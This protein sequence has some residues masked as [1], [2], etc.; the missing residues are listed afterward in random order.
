MENATKA[1]TMAASILMALVIIG[2][3]LLV[4]NNLSKYQDFND[5]LTKDKHVIEFNNRFETYNRTDVRGSDLLSLINKVVDYNERQSF[6]GKEGSD[7]GYQPIK[8]TIDLGKNKT[9]IEV[10][11]ECDSDERII[12]NNN[13]YVI[14]YK[15][16]DKYEKTNDMEEILE[17][18]NDI[19]NTY[20]QTEL[21]KLV[22]AI[23]SIFIEGDSNGPEQD[24]AI[25]TYENI[26]GNDVTW[27][28][29]G[30]GKNIRKDVYKYSE[31]IQFKRSHFNCS[32][33]S[34]GNTPG[35]VYDEN[36]GRIIEM[37][38]VGNGKIE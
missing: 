16:T 5:Q 26:T 4:F 20:G 23:N 37:Y 21:T 36:T 14:Y 12:T 13:E 3:V 29:I 32:K 34:E 6:V 1:L 18:I 7:L 2:S 10:N 31:Y 30:P 15:G 22:V 28:D 27:N 19:E 17:E 38:F 25:K 9:N 24:K 8:L 11:S 33:D 35:V